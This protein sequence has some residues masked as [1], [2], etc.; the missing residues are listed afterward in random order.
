MSPL[1]DFILKGPVSYLIST[2]QSGP[3]LKPL[4]SK[5]MFLAGFARKNSI[6]SLLKKYVFSHFLINAV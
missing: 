1:Y 3:P 2:I 4:G 6:L 5:M